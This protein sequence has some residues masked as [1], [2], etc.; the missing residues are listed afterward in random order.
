MSVNKPDRSSQM[1][2]RLDPKI[3]SALQELSE[4]IG[5]APSTI[6]GLAIGEY[7][8]KSQ[9]VLHNQTFMMEVMGKEIARA[10]ASPL[11]SVLDGK[12]PEELKEI[13]RD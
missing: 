2:I 8:S 3:I 10:I 5:I 4:R 1:T 12:T 7:V 11:A 9:A 6:A 13:F